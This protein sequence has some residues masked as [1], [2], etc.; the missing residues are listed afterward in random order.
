MPIPIKVGKRWVNQPWQSTLDVEALQEMAEI[1]GGKFFAATD[2]RKLEEIYDEIDQLERTEYEVNESNYFTELAQWWIT[3]ALILFAFGFVLE[4]T[5][6]RS[7][8]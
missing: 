2:G 5:W 4:Q 7:F 6:L 3:P 8:P 1:T